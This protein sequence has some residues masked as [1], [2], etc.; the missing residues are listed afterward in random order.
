MS[1]PWTPGPWRWAGYRVNGGMYLSG[2]VPGRG[3]VNVMDFVRQGL[4]GA[5]PRFQINGLMEK[6][7]ELAVKE[8]E[9]REDIVAVDHPDARLIA[10][11]PEMA[12]MLDRIL[13]DS[14]SSQEWWPELRD[15]LTR[16]RGE[17]S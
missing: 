3:Q 14:G 1:E 15:L 11:A 10:A 8:V 7:E 9:Y 16:I 13:N 4:R 2:H 6:A 12:A 17:T 5:Q